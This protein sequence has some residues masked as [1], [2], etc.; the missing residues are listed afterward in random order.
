MSEQLFIRVKR[1]LGGRSLQ[2]ELRRKRRLGSKP[3]RTGTVWLHLF[4]SA[5]AAVDFGKRRLLEHYR[6]EQQ[7][8]ELLGDAELGDFDV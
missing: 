7:A 2:V 3:L 6:E 8:R 4:S 1:G 5:E